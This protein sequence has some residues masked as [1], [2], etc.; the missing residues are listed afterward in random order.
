M[1]KR[2]FFDLF[3]TLLKRSP[4]I[5]RLIVAAIYYRLRKDFMIETEPLK[6]LLHTSA[7]Q[8]LE[9]LSIFKT[10]PHM[11]ILMPV[12]NTDPEVLK[13]ASNQSFARLTKNGSFV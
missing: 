5:E 11:T 6:S 2:D 13:K 8:G 7:T 4:A 10:R 9:W 12:Y 3:A 1:C